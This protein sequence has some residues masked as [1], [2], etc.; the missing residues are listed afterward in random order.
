MKKCPRILITPGEPAGIGPD[1]TIIAAQQS[2]PVELI[3][4][5]DPELLRTRATLL[6]LPLTI[7]EYQA[8]E[9]AKPHE[10][11]KLKVIPVALNTPCEPGKLNSANS[12][13]VIQCLT[14]ATNYCLQH[15]T[16]ALVTGP[17]HKSI[18]NDAGIPFTGH[19]EFLAQHCHAADVIM[20]FVAAEMKVALLTTH[21]ALA[22][23]PG[24]IT[25]EKLIRTLRLLNTELKERFSIEQ[26]RILVCGLNPHA[27]E[28]GHLGREEIE[29]IEPALTQLR[30]ENLN[31][32]G[33]LPADTIFTE[34]YLNQADAILA[35]YHDQALPVVKYL[36][37]GHAVNVTLGL[38]IIRTSVDH[39][40]ALDI[41]GTKLADAGSL[42]AAIRLA[43]GMVKH[44]SQCYD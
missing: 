22:Q 23:V 13:Y 29:L 28:H 10:P 37:F 2:W 35:M 38:P 30:T 15:E 26:P 17:I 36:G 5:C 32:S 16:Q 21:L 24:A 12:A 33:P 31:V 4:V 7:E 19:T 6:Q 40:T 18:I 20:L 3:A 39:G 9:P 41:A 27:G 8:N 11:G 34:K 42:E 14:L 44:T 25:Q 43:I 1:V